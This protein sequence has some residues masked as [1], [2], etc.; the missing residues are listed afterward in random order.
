MTGTWTGTQMG[1][2]ITVVMTQHVGGLV[3]GTWEV[4]S[5]GGKGDVGPTGEPGKVQASGQFELR[6]KVRVGNY[7]DFYYRGTMDPT[8]QRLTGTLHNSGF[9]GDYMALTKQ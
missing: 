6:F 9:S 5:R 8:G 1:Y 7:Q 4:P 3:T 2:P